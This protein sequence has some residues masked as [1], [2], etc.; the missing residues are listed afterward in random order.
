MFK[1]ITAPLFILYFHLIAISTFAQ[2]D[3][4]AIAKLVERNTDRLEQNISDSLGLYED[5]VQAK[6]KLTQEQSNAL[7][8]KSYQNLGQWH[9]SEKSIDSVEFYYQ[10]AA[11]TYDEIGLDTNAAEIYLLLEDEYKKRAQYSKAMEVNFKA[12]DIYEASKNESGL[13]KVFTRLCDILYYQQEYQQGADYCQKAIDIQKNLNTPD[14]LAL[15]YRYKADN[16]LILA[17]YKDALYNINQAIEVLKKAN[18]SDN[19]LAPNYNTRGN[20]YKYLERYD[21]AITEYQKCYNIAKTSNSLSGLIPTLG[22]IGHVYRLQ[23][24]YEQALPYTLEAIEL[25]NETGELANLAENY[26]H[27]AGCYKAL[28]NY[29]KALEYQELYHEEKL[30]TLNLILD[31]LE[32]E[33]QI[34]YET[35]K[36]EETIV[37]QEAE[38]ERQNKIQQLYFGIGFLLVVILIGMFFTIRNNRKKRK[39]L[40]LLN[41]EVGK[42]QKQLEKSNNKL[43]A[44]LEELKATQNQ[45]I[46]SEKMASL[47]ELTAGIAHEIQNPLNFVNNFSEVSYEL[48]E[49]IKEERKKKKD[50][51]DEGLEDELLE[52]IANNLEKINHHGKRADGIVKGMLQH[53]R[54]GGNTKEPTNLNALADEYLRLAYHGLKAKDKN[55]NAELVT[56]FDESIQNI[57]VVPQD[58]GRVILN[59]VTNAFYVV[60]QKKQSAASGYKPK[61]SISTKKHKTHVEI[62]VADNGNGIP[63]HIK[64][65]IFQPFFTTK[66]TGEGTGLGLSLSYDIITKGH[67]GELKVE[68]QEAKG[69]TFTIELPVRN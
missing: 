50:E 11:Q 1:K 52:D 69:T 67:G 27:A 41:E 8:A 24:K 33:L 17:E 15:S 54:S 49:E 44:S 53:S 48:I 61:V 32:S 4:I 38:L 46:Q 56:N 63:E 59:L 2:N 26:M 25:M 22:N 68:T 18:R 64:D 28:G 55:F 16:L 20:I 65:K 39:E 3:S 62:K 58:I 5:L 47:G 42:N 10:N 13:A 21:D 36:K 51:R 31:Q 12:L 6:T 37:I 45:L 23:G 7:L 14:E 30:R 60:N 66:P 9:S 57:N 29:E 34:K 43:K 40:L 19:E 35:N